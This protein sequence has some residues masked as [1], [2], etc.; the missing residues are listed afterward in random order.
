MPGR[1]SRELHGYDFVGTAT[2]MHLNYK[3]THLPPGTGSRFLLT[4]L[5]GL[6]LL[7]VLLY[8]FNF[9]AERTGC[10]LAVTHP[11]VL[12][13]I[14]NVILFVGLGLCEAWLAQHVLG[15]HGWLI[16]FVAIDAALLSLLIET[17]QLWL[18]GRD[19][20]VIDLLANTL[21]AVFGGMLSD[22]F[23]KS[24]EPV[25]PSQGSE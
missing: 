7:T 4:C 22:A 1:D 19:S 21:G 12:S 24:E 18:P 16:L 14:A 9:Q 6:V 25:K 20:S 3:Q 13:I 5:I 17:V 15:R 8:P 2:P 10:W 23:A 11:S